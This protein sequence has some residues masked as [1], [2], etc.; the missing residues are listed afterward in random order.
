MLD[1]T[2][3]IATFGTLV[4]CVRFPPWSDKIFRVTSQTSLVLS[5]NSQCRKK[6]ILKILKTAALAFLVKF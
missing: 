5:L 4:Q 3:T 6:A 1:G 2:S